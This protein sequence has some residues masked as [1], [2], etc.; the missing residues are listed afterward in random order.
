MTLLGLTQFIY[1]RNV[2]T[3]KKYVD[4][5]HE[6][7]ES[8]TIFPRNIDLRKE[9]LQTNINLIAEC[10]NVR[11]L[12]FIKINRTTQRIV[13]TRNKSNVNVCKLLICK[14]KF[15]N[16]ISCKNLQKRGFTYCLFCNKNFKDF[17]GHKC[18]LQKCQMC[19]M[20][21]KKTE[22]SDIF[23]SEKNIK[24]Q[25]QISCL[26]C[27]KICINKECWER[28]LHLNNKYCRMFNQ[29]SSCGLFVKGQIDKHRCYEHFCRSCFVYH[30]KENF[31]SIK[32]KPFNYNSGPVI[33]ALKFHDYIFCS[34][35]RKI[36]CGYFHYGYLFNMC[37]NLCSIVE[38]DLRTLKFQILKETPFY[39]QSFLDIKNYI[40]VNL[41]AKFLLN[42]EMFT[43]FENSF[44]GRNISKIK[45]TDAGISLS[46][47]FVTK[48]S[49]ICKPSLLNLFLY[50]NLPQL[51][52]ILFVQI[53]ECLTHHDISATKIECFTKSIKNVSRELYCK[54]KS[55]K[56][57]LEEFKAMH[58][59]QIII[60]HF[61]YT[62]FL[63]QHFVGMY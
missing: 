34:P 15:Y 27:H 6:F 55:L 14:E 57:E 22:Y 9:A 23:C 62:L 61:S 47:G 37:G 48:L 52:N 63:V 24:V 25:E 20:Y 11:I 36:T 44:D 42:D 2:K 21:S 16:I 1:I 54:I 58:L 56:K 41:N 35:I 17:M 3:E 4:K 33:L 60:L 8:N 31:C 10:F 29:C 19:F 28:H 26:R 7:Y 53:P 12:L 45:A 39:G 30:K 32:I 38:L 40:N 49:T 50:F 59:N 51:K 43:Y 5:F 46:Y 18:R 13:A